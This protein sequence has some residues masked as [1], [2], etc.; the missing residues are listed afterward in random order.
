MFSNFSKELDKLNL[1]YK[2]DAPMKEH[3]SFK[4]GGNADYFVSV[5][6]T[7]ELKTIISLCRDKN[8]PY[9]LIGNGSNLLVDDEGIR[10]VVI[11]LEGDF[12]EIRIDGDFIEAGAGASLTKLCLDAWKASLTGLE[13]GYGI[14]G[15]VG[16]A[17]Y[18]NAGAYGGEM[19]DVLVSCTHLDSELNVASFTLDELDLNYR[20]S[21]YMKGEYIIL[22]VKL[23]LSK[24]DSTAIKARMDELMGK[25]MDKQ[26]LEYPSA[27]SVF[28]RPEGAF[29]AALIEE[30]GLK[31]RSVGGAQVS[32]KHSGFIVNKGEATCKDVLDLVE[33][34]QDEVKEKT[35][36]ELHR[37]IIYI[38]G[39]K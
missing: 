36:Y 37:E 23:K 4:I 19:K 15:S 25:R 7:E 17:A 32:E 5:K 31:G 33:I 14:P 2:K 20:H 9:M 10:G 28:K 30:C 27:G 24:G 16:G 3:T 38:E 12:K 35:G 39:G 13:F 34:I 26:P 1:E 8:V 11:R 29:A 18:M 21:A 22:S 6:N